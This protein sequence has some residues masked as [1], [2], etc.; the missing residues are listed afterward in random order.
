MSYYLGR[1][2]YLTPGIGLAKELEDHGPFAHNFAKFHDAIVEALHTLNVPDIIANYTTMP[3][4]YAFAAL[5]TTA[6]IMLDTFGLIDM[7]DTDGD[8]IGRDGS[9]SGGGFDGRPDLGL[10]LSQ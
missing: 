8:G 4:A 6:E 3:L 7:N 1:S 2:P 9:G 10:R 5:V